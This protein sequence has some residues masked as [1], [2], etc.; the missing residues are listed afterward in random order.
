MIIHSERRIKKDRVERKKIKGRRWWRILLILSLAINII[1]IGGV[2]IGGGITIQK[3]IKKGNFQRSF[4]NAKNKFK[5]QTLGLIYRAQSYI[6]PD[7]PKTYIDIKF[8]NYKKLLN[9]RDDAVK[10]GFLFLEEKEFVPATIRYENQTIPIKLRLKGDVI[11]QISG[12]KWAFRIRTEGDARFKGMRVFSIHD[13][14]F[15]TYANEFA[16]LT[17]LRSEGILAPRYEFID[18][19]INGKNKGIYALEENFSKELIE[20]Q[21]RRTGVIVKFK[22]DSYWKQL[23]DWPDRIDRS[24]DIVNPSYF[25]LTPR[26]WLNVDLDV[27]NKEYVAKDPSLVKQRDTALGLLAAFISGE[28]KASEVFDSDLMAKFLAITYLWAGDHALLW[29]NI[30]FYYN[31]ITSK[32]EPIGFNAKAGGLISNEDYGEIA[33]GKRFFGYP[34]GQQDWVLRVLRDREIAEKY[35]K[36]CERI[37][38]P[39][40]LEH[41][42]QTL[43]VPLSQ[44]LKILWREKP[45]TIDWEAIEFNRKFLY[46]VI[47]PVVQVE[48]YVE[49]S[50]NKEGTDSRINLSISNLL[51]LPVELIG[52][53]IGDENLIPF[54]VNQRVILDGLAGYQ[55]PA[56]KQIYHTSILVPS[57][58]IVGNKLDSKI[59]VEVVSRLLGSTKNHFTEIIR[60][61]MPKFIESIPQQTDTVEDLLNKHPF[62]DFDKEANALVI[63]QG[64][65][66]VK[67]DLIIPPDVKLMAMSGTTL[68]FEEGAVLLTTSPII[69]E[70]SEDN[71]VRLSSQAAGWGGLVV[72]NANGKSILNHVT[73]ENY[74]GIERAGWIL[75]GGVTF[76]N[77]TAVFNNFTAQ[78]NH[79]EDAVNLV[80]VGYAMYNS[81][82]KNISSDAL[83]NDFCQGIVKDTIFMD[84]KADALDV[85]GTNLKVE[86]MKAYRLGDKGLSVGEKSDVYAQNIVVEYAD[87]G[88]ASKDLSKLEIDNMQITGTKFGLAAYQKKPEYGPA[89]IRANNVSFNQVA[90]EVLCQT[91][92]FITANGKEC[93]AKDVD[94]DKLYEKWKDTK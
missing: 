49:N 94:I 54:S 64:S 1:V 76:Y 41:L 80:R 92:S 34:Y 58:Y 60:F 32:L 81:L 71:P 3:A 9:N 39:E 42:K 24:F 13:P 67:G 51:N 83:D 73:V 6:I 61:P 38:S 85:S 56:D 28:K 89:E 93:A 30:N 86:N 5:R 72:L 46:E 8:K 25:I 7:I 22:E 10:R 17:H 66:Q 26:A 44:Q 37:T 31:P 29:Q 75:T 14:K 84:I 12:D 35:I 63:K 27:F 91:G 90:E 65:W 15:R 59:K 70:G 68:K 87:F 16:Y 36:E 19:V 45:E 79:C 43:K 78:N 48:A 40:Y 74:T 21:N 33:S 77:T 2:I 52:I 11:E 53:R 55:L 57:K 69:F 18:V 47:N 4:E 50:I 23:A 62:L 82:F 20:S 88:A